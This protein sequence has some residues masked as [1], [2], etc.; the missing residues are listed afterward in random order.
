MKDH[1]V[2]VIFDGSTCLGEVLGRVLRFSSEGCI[3]QRLVRIAVLSKLL[4]GEELAR[5]LFQQ[6]SELVEV[7]F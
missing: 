7:C 4:P 3:V 6:N 2:S 5:E 1:D